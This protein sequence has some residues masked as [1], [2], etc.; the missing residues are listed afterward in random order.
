VKVLPDSSRL[1]AVGDDMLVKLWD[2]QTGDL[3][4]TFEGHATRT[5]Q[6]HVTALYV[7]AVS[8]DG[9][10]LASGDRIGEVRVWDVESG[11]LVQ[12]FQVPVLYTY[13]PVQRKR[14]IGGIRSLVFSP[15]GTRLAAGGIGQINN[16]DGL[17]GPAT[18]ELWDWQ[19]PKRLWSGGA[20][21]HQAIINDLAFHPSEPW[22]IGAGG[23]SDNG[24][25]AFW[26]TDPPPDPTA[27]ADK[28]KPPT[29]NAVRIKT[30]GHI[31]RFRLSPDATRLY[32]AGHGKLEVWAL[33]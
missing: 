32:A 25:I 5:P 8:P 3:L 1:A 13:D 23:G 29:V 6:G 4:R 22:L 26:K 15:D 9:K 21:G 14:S 24:M 33:A 16:V 28:D 7:V 17:S 19:A 11:S 27:E 2:A 12:S 31:H 10:L 30:D 20:D 18:V